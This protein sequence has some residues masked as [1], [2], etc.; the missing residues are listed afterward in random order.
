MKP[1]R[2]EFCGINSFSEPAVIDFRRL[3]D[4]G[5]FGIFGDTGSGKSTILDCIVYALYGT[6]PRLPQNSYVEFLNYRCREAYIDF[7]FEIVYAGK[8]RTYRV[9]HKLKRQGTDA[10]TVSLSELTEDGEVPISSGVRE[11][12]E[13]LEEI[14]GLNQND[15]S[16]CIALPQGEFSQFVKS[17]AR[18][19]L[20]LIAGLFDLEKYGLRLTQRINEQSGAVKVRVDVLDAKLEAFEDIT[21]EGN[22]ALKVHIA[23][24]KREKDDLDAAVRSLHEEEKDYSTRLARRRE[25]EEAARRFAEFEKRL[26][27]MEELGKQLSLLERAVAVCSAA[28]EGAELRRRATLADQRY[29]DAVRKKNSSADA[30]EAF[31]PE[32]GEALDGEIAGLNA[33]AVQSEAAEERK[34]AM[35]RAESRLREVLRQLEREGQDAG[36]SYEEEKRALEEKL[37]ACGEED[38][39]SFAETRG[40]AALLRGEYAQFSAELDTLTQKYPEISPDSVPLAEKYRALSRGDGTDF[41]RLRQAYEALE[42]EKK[43]LRDCLLALEEKR[44]ALALKMQRIEHLT[45]EKGRLEEELA[46]YREIQELPPAKTVRAQLR[47]KQEEKRKFSELS[48]KSAEE[49]SASQAALAAAEERKNGAHLALE[50]GIAR[51][52]ETMKAGGFSSPEEAEALVAKYGEGDA[53]GEYERFMHDYT[54]AKARC[55]DLPEEDFSAITPEGLTALR[56]EIAQKET[57]RADCIK[58]LALAEDRLAACIEGLKEKRALLE[59]RTEI[60]KH[61][62]RLLL[63]KKLIEGNRFVEFV[64][65]EY[66]QTVAVNAST[67]LLSLTDGRY[68]LRYE[69]GFTVGD[70]FN[71][72]LARP[73]YTLSGGET[74]LVSLSLAL[75]LGAEICAR[76]RPIEFFFLDEGFG[77]LDNKLVD[78]V[79]DSLERLRNEHFTIGIISHVEELKCRIDRKILVEKATEESGS[80]IK[81]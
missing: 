15:F 46:A 55:T 38:F 44:G 62:R 71:G 22:E 60:Y 30:L 19:R 56:G 3:T 47:A 28:K 61:Y 69:K 81:E 26:P 72:G 7:T 34:E 37:S 64:A 57:A 21:E 27:A 17:P 73:V 33:L 35:A 20:R 66:L 18:D 78:T 70:N 29:E 32:R 80:K 79:M 51:Y 6:T 36:F 10:H 39:F 74:F 9:I 75:A 53:R 8:R 50:E 25:A 54:V 1:I 49:Y 13:K 11:A 14:V 59:E 24:L 58:E 41:T 68:F 4:Y 2:L 40:K 67:R 48:R 16:K 43:R 12:Y 77:T 45:A 5:L 23:D 63:L 65:E 42:S 31:P 52:R 76:S